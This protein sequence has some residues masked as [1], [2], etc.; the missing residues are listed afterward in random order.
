MGSFWV[1]GP[2]N[3]L[4]PCGINARGTFGEAALP[5]PIAIGTGQALNSPPALRDKLRGDF[6]DCNVTNVLQFDDGL[7]ASTL[8]YLSRFIGKGD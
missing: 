4:P 2:L 1:K 3:P 7:Y 6:G 8:E 5:F